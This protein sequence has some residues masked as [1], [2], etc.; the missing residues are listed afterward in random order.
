VKERE[1]EPD[2]EP[3]GQTRQETWPGYVKDGKWYCD[4]NRKATCYTVNDVAKA[5]YGEKCALLPIFSL[6]IIL[7]MLLSLD[8]SQA[9]RS[10]MHILPVG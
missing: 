10:Q 4:C 3:A 7:N 6:R 1:R 5:K 9:Q 8:L 2:A